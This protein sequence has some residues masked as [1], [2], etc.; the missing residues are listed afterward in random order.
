MTETLLIASTIILAVL[1]GALLLMLL[2]GR[3][4]D[5]LAQLPTELNHLVQSMERIERALR[6]ELARNREETGAQARQE[7]TELTNSLEQMRRTVEEKLRELQERNEKKLEEMRATVDE[8]LHTTLERRLGESFK[9]VSERLELVH[10]GLGDMQTLASGVGDLKK[11]LMNVKTRGTWGEIQLGTLLDQILTP[12]QYARNIVTK[13]GGTER[14]EF[15]IRIPSKE[16]D[17]EF[18]FLPLDA[19]FPMDVYQRLV[20][21]AEQANREAVEEAGRSL[22]A[23]IKMEARR[24]KEKYVD[25]PRTTDFAILFL[26]TEGLYAEVT[27]RAGLVESLQREFRVT[28]LGPTTVAAF[29]NSLQMG[30]RTLAIE[31]RSSEVWA[32]L[33]AVKT[34]FGRF[35]EILDKTQKKLQEASNTIEDASRRS[36]AIERRLREVHQLPSQ[37]AEKLLGG[38]PEES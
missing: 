17:G 4:P 15:A 11:V 31:R 37:D 27:R 14:V 6:D 12:E 19:K 23:R 9:L 36:R 16:R 20:D 26:P 5:A 33:G 32:L 25:P 8:K 3:H 18:V 10:K 7:R 1:L 29:L 24:I 2:R 22:E 13:A 28:V 38:A 35:G 30:F 34:E 21:A